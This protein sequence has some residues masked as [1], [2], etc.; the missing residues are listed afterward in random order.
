M[1]QPGALGLTT[2]LALLLAVGALLAGE[3]AASQEYR[4]PLH[5]REQNPIYQLFYVPTMEA[6]EIRSPGSWWAG[7]TFAY[8]NIFEQGTSAT[9]ELL[10]D[11][12]RLSTT[13]S[14]AYG[15]T[16][17]VDAG[18]RITL[19]TTGGGVLDPVIEGLHGAFNLSN[20]SREDYPSGVHHV[21]LRE[22]AGQ[23]LYAV[24]SHAVAAEDVQI[25]TRVRL[26]GDNVGGGL[27]LRAS[28]Q[29]PT[30]GDGLGNG[31]A[32]AALTL[33]GRASR[34]HWSFHG[35]LGATHL[36]APP[37]LRGLS[38]DWG[39][40]WGAAADR[41]LFRSVSGVIQL[42]G[43]SRYVGGIG[44]TELDKRPL[45]LGVGLVGGDRW[46]WQVGFVEDVPPN[47]PSVDFTIHLQVSTVWR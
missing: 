15:M 14:L 41:P 26:T 1:A 27:V 18:A 40:Y 24:G 36:S 31:K 25:F 20:G 5:L 11:M 3:E 12:E 29:L 47:S 46:R 7:V 37:S 4:G 39:Y 43:A 35:L 42:Q 19:Q 17:R 16:D 45:I 9:H 8:S 10:V 13:L 2:R 34:G 22:R 30:A 44:A 6:A 38:S 32:D 33:L 23:E 28:L 21:Y